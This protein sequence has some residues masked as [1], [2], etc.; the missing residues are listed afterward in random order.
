MDN[1]RRVS[2]RDARA[3]A[4]QSSQPLIDVRGRNGAVS[5]DQSGLRPRGVVV[6]QAV[7]SDI[8]FPCELRER[9]L[10]ARAARAQRYAQ[11]RVSVMSC[12]RQ[13]RYTDQHERRHIT[14]LRCPVSGDE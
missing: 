3:A 13:C 2:C 4:T 9:A 12:V 14:L 11:T 1:L 6:R 5:K 10:D 7:E 8:R